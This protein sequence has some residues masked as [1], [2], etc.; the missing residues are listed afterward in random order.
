ML[1]N[2][3]TGET[4][5]TQFLLGGESVG[6][7]YPRLAISAVSAF[8]GSSHRWGSYWH[9]RPL[10]A[11]DFEAREA[12]PHSGWPF[13]RDHLT[14]YYERAERY[15]GLR[16]FDYAATTRETDASR[17]LTVRP[18]RLVTGELQHGPHRLS[19]YDEPP[20]CR[21]LQRNVDLPRRQPNNRSSTVWSK[22]AG[23]PL[24]QFASE[25]MIDET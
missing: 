20:A 16:P 10:D 24:T 11:L 23:P 7:P 19:G 1:E 25:R 22:I 4:W 12:I 21:S 18:G 3:G 5:R 13:G 2:G 6:Y 8:G 17:R 9:S 14:P 15:F